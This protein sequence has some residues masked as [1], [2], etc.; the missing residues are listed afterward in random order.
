[1][2]VHPVRASDNL[3]NS[4]QV[5]RAVRHLV[6]TSRPKQRRCSAQASCCSAST[7]LCWTPL[8]GH[9][10][11]VLLMI[12]A[13]LGHHP[14]RLLL[15]L[16][17][18]RSHG[19]HRAVLVTVT[20]QVSR[21]PLGRNSWSLTAS[22][23]TPRGSPTPSIPTGWRRCPRLGGDGRLLQREPDGRPRTGR[24]VSSATFSSRDAM[25]ASCSAAEALRARTA[26]DIGATVTDIHEF[27][28]ALA[29]LR[30]PEMV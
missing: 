12:T 6:R 27:E 1:M 30:V 22:A 18:G 5:V 26:T 2:A 25:V 24:A 3:L 14:H 13:D 20:G 9:R 7:A 8:L 17:L 15:Q 21:P 23:W 4:S 16:T 19:H 29:Q 28:L 10:R 11:P